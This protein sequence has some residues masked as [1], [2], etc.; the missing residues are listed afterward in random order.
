MTIISAIKTY[1]S[2]YGELKTDAPIWVD[3]FGVSPTEYTILPLPGNRIVETY[4]SGKSK[5]EYPFAFQSVESTSDELERL[6]TQGFYEAFADWLE[7]QTESGSFPILATGQSATEIEALG[8]AYLYQ[9]GES[10]TGIYQVQCRLQ[11]TQ[12]A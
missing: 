4:L 10:G 1:L 3:Y 6:E 7:S 5:R 8:W 12:E 2:D 9:Q 11:Y